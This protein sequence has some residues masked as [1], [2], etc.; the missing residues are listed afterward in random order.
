MRFVSYM[1]PGF[2]ESLFE[3]LANRMGAEVHFETET[4]GPPAEV[5]PFRDGTF[6]L[7][8]ICSTSFVDL[9]LRA[10]AP[11]VQLAGVAWVP[12]DPDSG[13][14]PVY[15]G[16][17]V[18]AAD[19]DADSLAELAGRRIAC[20][21]VVSLSGHYAL[22]IAIDELGY[23]SSDFAEL[24]FTGGHHNS[25]DA[26]VAG[27]VD[28]CVVDSVVRIGRSRHDTAVADLRLVDRL[29]P[30]PVQPL[31]ARH[32]LSPEL[33]AEVRRALLDANDDP[34]VVD[35]LRAAAL[36]HLV[37]VDHTHYAPVREALERSGLTFP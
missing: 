9:A 5:D 24:V 33:V 1:S 36:T 15:F 23:D 6:D 31:V 3:L 29:G 11:S 14:R 32:D 18:V 22:R 19:S 8:W 34:E 26:L 17:L 25:L 27:E 20:N 28:A 2:P 4:S 37:P 13:G 7:G 21:D 16:D 12:D 10:E 30:W 35:A